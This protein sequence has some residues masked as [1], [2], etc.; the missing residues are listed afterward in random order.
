MRVNI[1]LRPAAERRAVLMWRCGLTLALLC[2]WE[3]YGRYID[4]TWFSR[5]SLIVGR[6][7][8]WAAGDLITHVLTTFGE[9]AGGLLIGV[10]L[11]TLLGLVLGRLPVIAGLVRPIIFGLYSIPLVTLAPLF[12]FWF[13]LGMM[14]KVVLV[15][16]VTFFLLFFTTFTG[17]QTIDRDLIAGFRL[18]GA[19]R[20]ELVRKLI[21]PACLA[22]ILSGLKL[23][24]PF[25][26][27]AAVVGEMLLARAGLGYLLMEASQQIDMTGM[28]AAVSILM[29]A[30]VVV[31]E[32]VNLVERRAMR[33]RTLAA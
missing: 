30:G 5:P 32:A 28:F 18:L 10:P 7:W 13:G 3:F 23:A 26:L 24:L 33:W 31:G 20:T 16:I 8:T 29:L 9:M 15:S 17:V 4:A 19:T 22:W 6:I 2:A 25:S 14:P 11:G 1:A 12:I 27:I 21:A